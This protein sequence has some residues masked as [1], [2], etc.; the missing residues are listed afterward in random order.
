MVVS[1][2]YARARAK[3]QPQLGKGKGRLASRASSTPE[4][5]NSV[6]TI[7]AA[8]EA[9]RQFEIVAAGRASS[10]G[11]EPTS[12]AADEARQQRLEARVAR[13][14]ERRRRRRT[15]SSA[16]RSKLSGERSSGQSILPS[17]LPTKSN[18][19]TRHSRYHYEAYSGGTY[20]PLEEEGSAYTPGEYVADEE[21][22]G[23]ADQLMNASLSRAEQSHEGGRQHGY[24]ARTS[25]PSAQPAQRPSRLSSES[26]GSACGSTWDQTASPSLSPLPPTLYGAEAEGA[27]PSLAALV[28]EADEA[29]ADGSPT[30]DQATETAPLLYAWEATSGWLS[31]TRGPS[32]LLGVPHVSQHALKADL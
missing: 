12:Y 20:T 11:A 7:G 22:A 24:L 18:P 2:A 31:E 25:H 1:D 28:P 6:A 29:A 30:R 9:R 32:L 27:Q 8:R 10:T 26:P 14:E 4:R 5:G 13:L 3:A 16:T 17:K 19:P 21:V 15:A 23:K